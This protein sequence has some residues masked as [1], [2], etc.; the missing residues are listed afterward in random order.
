MSMNTVQG[1]S[2]VRQTRFWQRGFLASQSAYVLVALAVL[3]V[4][5][6]LA[7]PNFLTAGNIS[8]VARNFSFIAI[9]TLGITLVI[10]TGGIDLS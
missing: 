9:A 2:N 10:I 3:I 1:F 5:M 4:V 6:H 7:S 8:N